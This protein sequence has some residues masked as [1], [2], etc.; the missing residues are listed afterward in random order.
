VR[1]FDFWRLDDQVPYRAAINEKLREAAERAAKKDVILILENEV[2][3]NTATA[4]EAAKVL[5]EFHLATAAQLGSGE[6]GG[7]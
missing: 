7:A 4:A 5:K 2:A 1:F 3:C 6:R